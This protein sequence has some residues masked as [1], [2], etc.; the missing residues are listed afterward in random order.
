MI[1]TIKLFNEKYSETPL[2]NYFELGNCGVIAQ[3]ELITYINKNYKSLS[4]K[5]K[6]V[7]IVY[8]YYGFKT[9]K[10][11]NN[12]IKNGSLNW[13]TPLIS[14]SK[15]LKSITKFSA[16][17]NYKKGYKYFCIVKIQ[18]T[19]NN[20]FI[21]VNEFLNNIKNYS[22]YQYK[23]ENEILLYQNKINDFTIIKKGLTYK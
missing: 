2:Y 7:G 21:D 3:N 5:C 12:F 1:T 19:I 14:C 15:D 10:Q 8:R 11:F 16:N 6:Y 13:F 9:L 17:V 18:S 22:D 23:D 4:E 20:C